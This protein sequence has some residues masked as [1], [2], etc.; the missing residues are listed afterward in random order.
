MARDIA[1]EEMAK[2]AR[3]ILT[4]NVQLKKRENLVVEGFSHTLD[5][6]VAI[7]REARHLGAY[8]LILYE[9]EDAYWDA[10]DRREDAL[11]GAAPMHEWAMLGKTNVY[12]HMWGIGDKVRLSKLPNARQERTVAFNSAWYETAR[13]AGLRGFRLELGRPFPNLAEAYGVDEDEWMGQ[14]LAATQVDPESL[15]R[16]A[17]PIARALSTGRKVRIRDSN[18]T[19]LTLGLRRRPARVAWGRVDVKALASPFDR[20]QGLPSG[21]MRVAL[22]ETVADGT[23]VA[24]RTDYIGVGTATGGTFEFRKGRLV[25][26]AFE[27]GAELFDQDFAKGGKGRDQPGMLGIGLNPKLHNTPQLEDIERGAVMVTV[28]GNGFAG[29]KNRSPF[30]GFAI[31]VGARVEVDGRAL[32]GIG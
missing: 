29:G 12:L 32:P 4:K 15:R 9:N 30:F 25:N 28:G 8:P 21:A 17:T 16:A 10:L 11:L 18:G 19:D 20:M 6:A 23:F 26:H 1:P 3:S 27:H 14:V 2:V 5:W 24:N 7:A 31:N 13:K 22:D